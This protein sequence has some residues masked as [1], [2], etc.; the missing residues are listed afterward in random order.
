MSAVVCLLKSDFL[1][2][3][4][5]HNSWK[6]GSHAPVIHRN[7]ARVSLAGVALPCTAAL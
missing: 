6:T 4:C 2:N 1:V 3:N 7:G 5:L